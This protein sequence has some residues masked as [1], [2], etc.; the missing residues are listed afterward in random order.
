MTAGLPSGL[1]APSV[2]VRGSTVPRIYT[3]PRWSG[4][5]GPCGCGCALRP[6]T[7]RGFEIIAFATDVLR[8]ALLPW[9]RWWLIH[10]FELSLDVHPLSGRRRPRYRTLLTLIARQQGKSWILRVVALWA[11]YVRRVGMV[12][13]AAQSLD[14]ARESWLGAVEL[15]RSAPECAAEIPA[16]GGVRMTNGEQCL[17]LSEGQRYRITAATRGAGRGLTVDV[18]LLDELREHRDYLAWAALS[19]T[20]LA[21]PEA[22]ICAVSNAGDDES[23]V[24][25]DLRA[26]AIE[27]ISRC[28]GEREMPAAGPAEPLA[29]DPA[30]GLF[31]AEWS[32]RE[33]CPLDDRAGWA[34]AM[35]G[36]NIDVVGPRGWQPAPI[37]TEAV[38]G[39][40]ATD[41]PNVFRTELLCI[42][43][44]ALDTAYDPVEWAACADAS[45]SL[46]AHRDRI[47]VCVDVSL[48]GEHVTA[49]GAV[50]LPDGR[51]G[52]AVLGAWSGRGAVSAAE[53]VLPGIL[54]AIRPIEIGWYPSS[55]VGALG[56]VLRNLRRTI[57]L[58]LP[59]I[60]DDPVVGRH[61]VTH[62]ESEAAKISSTM[63][64]ESAQGLG[65][66]LRVRRLVHPA[67]PLL[68][69]QVP[70]AQRVD[71]PG[72]ESGW[73]LTRRGGG[74]CDA[75]YAAAGAVFLAR[76]TPDP[77]A[78]PQRAR[79]Y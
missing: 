65:D 66:L 24:L 7:S 41:P 10:A 11:L 53:R 5:P 38:L 78:R 60:V 42:R 39:F 6:A 58:A 40:L 61:L 19:K 68:D 22:L 31:L 44:G 48:D 79:I 57:R 52:V 26:R 77:P 9:Q 18:L 8:V 45:F 23:I 20:T 64:R 25:N 70:A 62:D 56:P 74:H 47:A 54:T 15:A 4:P 34:Q 28:H 75:A 50:T 59:K 2:D 76:V 69:A 16:V 37:T 33:G 29:A 27:S 55:P 30:G 32:A 46:R 14:I 1:P 13:G 63:E 73:R 71:A 72:G 36:L 67:D 21:R 3:P 49:C 35:P 17:T 51:A 43:V 12:L